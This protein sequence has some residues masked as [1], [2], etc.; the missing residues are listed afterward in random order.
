MPLLAV[1]IVVFLVAVNAFYVTAEYAV[2][3]V[4]RPR[5]ARLRREG[6]AFAGLLE[7]MVAEPRLMDRAITACQIGISA[8][9]LALGAYSQM[10]LAPDL[11]PIL[12]GWTG[13]SDLA[14]HTA[15]VVT[16]LAGTSGLQIVLGEQVPK[17]MAV[18]DPAGWGLRTALPLK[19][20]MALFAVFIS[21]LTAMSNLILKLLR[22]PALPEHY[23][24]SSTEIGW[25]VAQSA[26][27]GAL[28]PEVGDRLHNAL[29]FAGRTA[30]D[31][32]VPRVRVRAVPDTISMDE[33]RRVVREADHTRIPVYRDSLDAILG[34]IHAKDVLLRTRGG[35]PQPR[36]ADLVRPIPL[37]PWSARALS[38]LETM[39]AEHAGM[40]VVLDEH[41]GTAGIVTLED[42]V[43]EVFGE[44]E[45][46]FDAAGPAIG[47]LPDGRLRLRAEDAIDWINATYGLRLRS[48]EARTVGGLLMEALNR[49]A[50]PGDSIVSPGYRLEVERV[51]GR[52][53]ETVLAVP[54]GE[55]REP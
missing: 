43:E 33:L 40:V 35:G 45:D 18:R 49:V 17:T 5:A 30:M 22:L 26:R 1:L 10:A 34:V 14:A 51:S 47:R 8:S 23:L 20:S 36:P 41:G 29:R 31:M 54:L 12:A 37:V 15:A 9:S 16:I 44:V 39:R 55:R 46:E 19:A 53:I 24:H 3:G 4:G 32:M 27:A 13:W 50:R 28:R 25:L 21:A 48:D 2:V 38:L 11:A 6:R 42:L 52:R 7:S